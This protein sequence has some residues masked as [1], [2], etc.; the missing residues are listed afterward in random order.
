MTQINKL[1][2]QYDE[3][4]IPEELEMV[5]HSAIKKSK[6]K[7][8]PYRGWML[9]AAAASLIFVTSLNVSPAFARTMSEVPVIGQLVEVVTFT[10]FKVDEESYQAN[11]KVPAV[12][13]LQNEQLQATLNEK[14]LAENKQLY[15]KFK[16]EMNGLEKKGGSY[17]GVD[18]SYEVKTDNDQLLSIARYETNTAA[19]AS[20][21]V[22]YDTIDKKN[23]W[24]ITLPSLF[25]D[26]SYVDIISKNIIS[27]M[28]QQMQTDSDKVYFIDPKEPGDVF[29]KIGKDQSFYITEDGKLVIAFDE[30]E[31]APGYMGIV[32][33]EIPSDVLKDMLVS[34]EYI[35]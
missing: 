32:E 2:Q 20:N 31:V 8:K 7:K 9:S 3:I 12:E 34:K 29:T 6:Q 11:L 21:A 15:E 35:K 22:K 30:Y 33:F 5:V 28:Q 27:Q 26:D 24:L 17:L 1:K 25:K 18:T 4:L 16:K 19:S 13:G 23:Q 10:E 14:Y